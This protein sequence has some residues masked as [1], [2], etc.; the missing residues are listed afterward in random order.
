MAT[1]VVMV[2]RF[3]GLVLNEMRAANDCGLGCAVASSLD[4][5]VLRTRSSR[6]YVQS[7]LSIGSLGGGHH[8]NEIHRFDDLGGALHLNW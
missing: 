8:A 3:G 1:G 5:A 4:R 2:Q 6:G 7:L